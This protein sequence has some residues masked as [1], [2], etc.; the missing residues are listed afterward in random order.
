MMR[1]LGIFALF[2]ILP[3]WAQET[4]LGAD[5]RGEGTRFSDS[6]V[7]PQGGLSF[8]SISGCGQVLL[9]DHPL[10]IAV[11]SLAPGN[12]V[13]MGLAL[14]THY[15][16]NENWRLFWN[17]DAV[18]TT[19]GSWRAGGYMTAVLIR[20]PNITVSPG[21]GAGSGRTAS[22]GEMEMPAFHAYAQGISLNHLEYFGLGPNTSLA[23]RSLFGMQQTVVGGNV[24]WP[25]FNPLKLSLF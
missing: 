14:V 7:H 25:V 18:G 20:H 23:G 5:F 22:T 2:G 24:V 16:P 17:F 21:T 12:G 6:C 3:L 4:Q 10:H 11:G 9:T 13:G 19:N 8:G 15:T 1:I